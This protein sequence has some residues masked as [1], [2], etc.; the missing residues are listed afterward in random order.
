MKLSAHSEKLFRDTFAY[1]NVDN[2]YISPLENYLIHGLPPGSFF[3]SLLA[4]DAFAT[5]S[6]S[7]PLN[8]I[9]NL[10]NVVTWINE[11]CPNLSYGSYYRV[12]K[13]YS[14][15]SENRRKLLENVGLIYTEHEE[16]ELMLK[17]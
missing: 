16:L 8:Q 12:N 1:H 13:W 14:R 3:E 7:H 11:V 6:H 10:K 17:E 9:V 2:E 4:N 15:T 5:I